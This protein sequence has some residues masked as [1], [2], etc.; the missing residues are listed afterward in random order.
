[1]PG[2]PAAPCSCKAGQREFETIAQLIAVARHPRQFTSR[3]STSWPLYAYS[4]VSEASST[5]G[6]A[7]L[8]RMLTSLPPVRPVRQDEFEDHRCHDHGCPAASAEP[9][10]DIGGVREDSG[11]GPLGCVPE[12]KHLTRQAELEGWAHAAHRP[13]SRG[14][15]TRTPGGCGLRGVRGRRRRLRPAG[16]RAARVAR[17][18]WCRS[19]RAQRLA[20]PVVSTHHVGDRPHSRSWASSTV[21]SRFRCCAA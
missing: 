18:S 11:V 13:A 5:Q 1:M 2:G 14:A 16:P 4:R 12:P 19:S 8:R 15:A 17:V 20:E 9:A 6:G 21:G 10:G 3:Y 7:V